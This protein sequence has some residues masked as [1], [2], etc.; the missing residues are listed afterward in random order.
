MVEQAS[1]LSGIGKASS[2][3]QPND[4]CALNDLGG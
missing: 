3:A 4:A 2:G 1:S